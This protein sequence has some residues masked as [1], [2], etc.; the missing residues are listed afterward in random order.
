MSISSSLKCDGIMVIGTFSFDLCFPVNA[1]INCPG[2][3]VLEEAANTK[4]EI[5]LLEFKNSI[6]HS[7]LSPSL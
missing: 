7:I 6:I 4:F 1:V 5:N 2:L 3:D